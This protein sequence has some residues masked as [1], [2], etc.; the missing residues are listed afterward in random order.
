MEKISLPSPEWRRRV[1]SF[2]EACCVCVC[3]SVS[4]LHAQAVLRCPDPENN[5]NLGNFFVSCILRAL[6]AAKPTSFG[7]LPNV[8]QAAYRC[9]PEV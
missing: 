5:L 7:A 4:G 1:R 6:R 3:F 8:L 2:R 9:L